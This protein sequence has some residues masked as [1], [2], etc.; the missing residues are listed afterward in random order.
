[1]A[2]GFSGLALM[3]KLW[4][5]PFLFLCGLGLGFVNP[6]ANLI[7]S[8]AYAPSAAAALNLFGFAWASGA[9]GA[10]FAIAVFLRY[11]PPSVVFLGLALLTFAA[12]ALAF[13]AGAA[14]K[15]PMPLPD[16]KNNHASFASFRG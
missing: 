3:V 10:P 1:M 4:I 14:A 12:V 15:L 13:L 9:L 8:R 6:A 16:R 5:P 11:E 2:F 7:V